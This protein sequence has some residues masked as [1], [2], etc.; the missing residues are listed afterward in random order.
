MSSW[1]GEVR[2]TKQRIGIYRAELRWA[3]TIIKSVDASIESEYERIRYLKKLREY[4]DVEWKE[5]YSKM[6]NDAKDKLAKYLIRMD[7]VKKK[8]RGIENNIKDERDYLRM[9]RESEHVIRIRKL[10]DKRKSI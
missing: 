3:D 8:R 7:E 4:E 6:M 9:M 10:K 2:A 5:P 1:I